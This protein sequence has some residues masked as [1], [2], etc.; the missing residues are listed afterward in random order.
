MEGYLNNELDRIR[1]FND[2]P[3]SLDEFTIVAIA[4]DDY[5]HF[6]W[7]GEELRLSLKMADEIAALMA[8]DGY[9]P[10][11]VFVQ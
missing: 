11:K 8:K 6:I 1:L 9:S 7:N 10:K 5:Y 3:A 4:H 2:L